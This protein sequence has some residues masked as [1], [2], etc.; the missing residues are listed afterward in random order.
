MPEE[1]QSQPDESSEE[2]MGSAM[3]SKLPSEVPRQCSNCDC[4]CH[5]VDSGANKIQTALANLALG[6]AMKKAL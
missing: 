1:D 2:K 6:N 3:E 4:P 5:L